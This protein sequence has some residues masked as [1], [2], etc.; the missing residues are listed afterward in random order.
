MYCIGIIHVGLCS[1]GLC[2]AVRC[3]AT[4]G[5]YPNRTHGVDGKLRFH[6]DNPVRL[7]GGDPKHAKYYYFTFEDVAIGNP[8]VR[9][10]EFYHQQVVWA[11]DAVNGKG[12]YSGSC[13]SETGRPIFNKKAMLSQR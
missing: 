13:I 6:S 7:L 9:H 8:K 3:L 11:M 1:A 2:F 12:R 4:F 5:I 10:Y